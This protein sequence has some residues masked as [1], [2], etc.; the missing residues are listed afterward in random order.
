MSPTNDS[1]TCNWNLLFSWSGYRYQGGGQGQAWCT[2]TGRTWRGCAGLF[3]REFYIPAQHDQVKTQS[4]VLLI[5]VL[6]MV[7][8]SFFSLVK[9]DTVPVVLFWFTVKE[10]NFVG[11]SLCNWSNFRVLQEEIFS[12]CDN[13]GAI[14]H[15]NLFF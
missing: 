8:L 11:I 9:G 6:L 4:V 13:Q 15:Q 10:E 14:S 12:D 7:T 3:S 1:L 2:C 5:S